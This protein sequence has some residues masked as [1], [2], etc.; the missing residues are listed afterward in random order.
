MLQ[1]APSLSATAG[2]CQA[3]L[4]LA[5]TLTSLQQLFSCGNVAGNVP[6]IHGNRTSLRET[7]HGRVGQSL[8]R[9]AKPERC[10]APCPPVA[11]WYALVQQAFNS[12]LNN[13]FA[14][15]MMPTSTVAR[16]FILQIHRAPQ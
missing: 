12:W 9:W 1:L 8:I 4:D 14:D 15:N 3:G 6:L 2:P 11:E 7:W 5:L 13:S 16:R 10:P